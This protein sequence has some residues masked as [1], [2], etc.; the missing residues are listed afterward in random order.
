MVHYDSPSLLF[1]QVCLVHPLPF[2]FI[3]S[4]VYTHR[5]IHTLS[6]WYYGNHWQFVVL[7]IPASV[8]PVLAP[9]SR[10]NHA[11]HVSHETHGRML[12]ID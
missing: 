12:G 10:A 5:L 3:D 7:R 6:A 1:V 11:I 2:S 8:G 4:Y 9:L